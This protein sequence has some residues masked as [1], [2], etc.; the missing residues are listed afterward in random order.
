[1]LGPAIYCNSGTKQFERFNAAQPN[2]VPFTRSKYQKY[3][4]CV[5]LYG[6]IDGVNAIRIATIQ[7]GLGRGLNNEKLQH[8]IEG[9]ADLIVKAVNCHQPLINALESILKESK[10]EHVQKIALGAIYMTRTA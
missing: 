9:Q 6:E 3:E 8:E 4:H 10:D 2:P 5:Y 1:M 7:P